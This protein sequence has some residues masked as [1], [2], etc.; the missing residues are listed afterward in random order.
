MPSSMMHNED[1]EVSVTHLSNGTTVISDRI[2][3]TYI[4]ELS[5]GV[6]QYI[7]CDHFGCKT[8]KDFERLN[9]E[10]FVHMLCCLDEDE[11]EKARQVNGV[12]AISDLF[13]F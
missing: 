8:D 13:V 12:D 6:V 9:H 2:S 3:D 4:T 5:D 1:D 10:C 11:L 7:H